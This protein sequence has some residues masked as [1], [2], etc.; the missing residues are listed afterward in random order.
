MEK[1]LALDPP[2]LQRV[3]MKFF[4]KSLT[5]ET[6]EQYIRH[7][8]SVAGCDRDIFTANAYQRIFDYT[9]GIPRLINTACDNAMLEGY[10]L[11]RETIDAD[12]IEQVVKDLGLKKD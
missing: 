11:K 8:L 3:A 4:I 10:L 5:R 12:I 1:Y 7:R 2:L 6:T 9:K